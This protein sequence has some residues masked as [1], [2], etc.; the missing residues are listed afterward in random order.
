MYSPVHETVAD[1]AGR[2]DVGALTYS[3]LG[4]EVTTGPFVAAV[5]D[6]KLPFLTKAGRS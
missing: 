1:G 5:I 2:A 4:S 6:F 3:G